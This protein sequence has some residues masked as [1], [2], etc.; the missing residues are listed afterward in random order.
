LLRKPGALTEGEVRVMRTHTAIGA[1]ILGGSQ[2]PLLQLAECIAVSHHERWDGSGYPHGQAGIEIPAAG[3][4]VAVADAFD[5][6]TNNRPY[7]PARSANTAL[8]LLREQ[9]DRHYEG[10]LIDALEHVIIEAGVYDASSVVAS[11][12]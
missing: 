11:V 4:I 2:V 6:I 3:R 8:D 12:A 5:A 7:R 10:R 1:R 9:Y